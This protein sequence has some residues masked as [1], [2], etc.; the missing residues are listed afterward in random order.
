MSTTKT[1]TIREAAAALGLTYSKVLGLVLRR[2]LRGRQV[3]GRY[4]TWRVARASVAAYRRTLA[5]AGR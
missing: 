2:R 1:M 4:T 3:A 5:G